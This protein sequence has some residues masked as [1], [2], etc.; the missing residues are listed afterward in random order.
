MQWAPRVGSLAAV[1]PASIEAAAQLCRANSSHAKALEDVCRQQIERHQ[2]LNAI[3]KS[4]R[5]DIKNSSSSSGDGRTGAKLAGVPIAVKDNFCIANVETTCSSNAL[6]N[7]VPPYTA[8][9]V[10]RLLDEGAVV[11]GKTNMD[12]FGMGSFTNTGI[13]GSTVNPWTPVTS[14]DALSAGGS[15]GGSA[16]AVASGMCLAALGSDTGGS[17]RLPAAYCG[18]VGLKP[19]YGRSSRHGLVAYASSLDTPGVLARSVRDAA[20]IA[21]VM[22]GHDLQD[23]SCA[24]R[25][26]T[27]YL[28]EAGS[29][30]SLTVGIPSEYNI[31]ELDSEVKERW[32]LGIEWLQRAG[33]TIKQVSLP[34]TKQALSTYYILAVCEA[35][36]NLNRYDG[37][38]YG[39]REGTASEYKTYID[40][41]T[42]SRSRMFGEE[43]MSRILT[44]TFA[45]SRTMSD[46]YYVQA[47]RVRQLVVREFDAIF[48]SGV[49]VLLTPTAP[50][51][52]PSLA[53]VAS[54]PETDGYA[55]DVFT[56]PASLAGLPAMSVP[57]GFGR[58]G[59]PV[60]LQLIAQRFNEA[61]VL[62]AGIVLEQMSI[63]PQQQ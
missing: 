39:H 40:M 62:R 22:S 47:Q 3:V 42:A 59:L 20:L 56:V 21:N 41:L 35:A 28:P 13:H 6:R 46:S 9:V 18:V 8:T 37:M 15:S 27:D 51:V 17:V 61:A 34:L 60:G 36:S 4:C 14:T 38:R 25:P 31:E 57:A 7:F 63:A 44:G 52:A 12:E 33:A 23:S 45:L 49:D 30:S 2:K 10:Q 5:I 48:N 29:L 26:P 55:N 11:V 1:L 32:S 19:S 50:T 43:V 53:S 24:E 16:A 58:D 54:K